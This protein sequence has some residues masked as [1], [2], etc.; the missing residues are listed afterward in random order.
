MLALA[1]LIDWEGGALT[2]RQSLCRI[3]PTPFI[4]CRGL[5]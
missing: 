2:A 4:V 5:Q 1:I 3:R